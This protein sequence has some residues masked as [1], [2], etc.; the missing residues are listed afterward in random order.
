MLVFI[1]TNRYVFLGTFI[2]YCVLN[3]HMIKGQKFKRIEI[4]KSEYNKLEKAENK[5]K[6]AKLLRRIQTFKLI[7]FGW[8]YNKISKFLKVTNDT[9]TAWIHI[10]QSG[11]IDK[12]INFNYKGGQPLLNQKQLNE[13]KLKAKT[14]KFKVAKEIQH[15]IEINFKVKY[16][17]RHVQ[18]LS[19]KN[20][21]YPLNEQN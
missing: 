11:G 15:Y 12:L 2:Y 17:L 20:F 9:I 3:K 6:S 19:K 5:I 13:L 10:Y 16:G 7:Y 14:G 1:Y 8:K 21:N 4:T 18:L